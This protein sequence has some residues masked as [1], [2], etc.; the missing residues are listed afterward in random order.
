MPACSLNF[1]S[2]AKFHLYTGKR[3]HWVIAG[4]NQKKPV[5]NEPAHE[6][7]RIQVAQL[8]ALTVRRA[9]PVYDI[10]S[11]DYGIYEGLVGVYW[12]ENNGHF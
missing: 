10:G 5:P 2:N 8:S 7:C 1:D 11:W 12:L 4:I 9:L 3:F 6:H